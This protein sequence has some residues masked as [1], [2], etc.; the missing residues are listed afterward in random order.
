M[1]GQ[2][3]LHG[4]VDIEG[5][6]GS[7]GRFYLIDFARVFPPEYFTRETWEKGQHLYQQLRPELVRTNSVPL[8]SDALSNFGLIDSETHNFE[9]QQATQRLLQ[10]VRVQRDRSHIFPV[11]LLVI[12][13]GNC[14]VIPSFARQMERSVKSG[15]SIT[16]FQL[17][18]D[19]HRF[20]INMRHMGNVRHRCDRRGEASR[21]L[22]TE[23]VAR[24]IKNSLR[25]RL[26]MAMR[27]VDAAVEGPFREET[28]NYLNLVFSRQNASENSLYWRTEVKVELGRSFPNSLFGDEKDLD[29]DLRDSGLSVTQLL[30]RVLALSAV[31][32]APGTVEELKQDPNSFELVDADILEL[33][34]RTK[35]L[36]IVAHAQAAGEHPACAAFLFV[37]LIRTFLYRYC[38]RCQ[39]NPSVVDQL[40]GSGCFTL[41][42][43]NTR[44]RLQRLQIAKI[45]LIAMQRLSTSS[46]SAR[47]EWI[48]G[49]I[50]RKPSNN[51]RL[52]LMEPLYCVLRTS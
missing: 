44:M 50:S 34:V 18:S 39:C 3:Y 35:Q 8:S 38:Q 15:Q 42:L 43:Q 49:G 31:K 37:E 51:G 12:L 14:Q 40:A 1:A 16:G 36:N 19:L 45:R 47:K 28:L 22:L 30:N 4:P 13:F 21:L 25:R 33:G 6:Y 20:G 27:R 41:Q 11:Y 10:E 17:C 7:D 5:H 2:H 52:R 29:F 24:E 23:M 32:L 26:R 46:L 48:E 9:V